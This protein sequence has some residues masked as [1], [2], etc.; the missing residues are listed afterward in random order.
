MLLR[1]RQYQKSISYLSE[2]YWFGLIADSQTDKLFKV[3][4]DI[5]GKLPCPLSPLLLPLLQHHHLELETYSA[6]SILS[7]QRFKVKIVSL[8]IPGQN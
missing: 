4:L 8:N 5:L 1:Q 7:T 6:P 3:R 2:I